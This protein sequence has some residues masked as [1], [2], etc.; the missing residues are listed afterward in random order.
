MVIFETARLIVR[1]F[2]NNDGENFFKINGNEEVVRYIRKPLTKEASDDF[3]LQN[4]E[5]YKTNPHLGRWAVDDKVTKEFVGSCVLIPLPFEDEKDNM[6]IGYALLPSS[7]GK[8][9][10]T[11]L[12]LAGIDYFFKQYTLDELHAITSIPNINSQKVLLKCGFIENGTKA[13]GEELLQR[14]LLKRT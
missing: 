4:I 8:G 13:E 9:Y 6:Q 10:A 3:L 11:E 2:A 7:W 5:L 1:Q 12:T 14:F